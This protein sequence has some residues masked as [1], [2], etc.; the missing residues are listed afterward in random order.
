MQVSREQFSTS[1][2]TRLDQFVS[3]VPLCDFPSTCITIHEWNGW[4]CEKCILLR[5]SARLSVLMLFS[6]QSDNQSKFQ[7]Y[8]DD[9]QAMS[10]VWCQFW[11]IL[12]RWPLARVQVSRGWKCGI[13][14][15]WVLQVLELG[16]SSLLTPWMFNLVSV[17]LL[18]LMFECYA[19]S[20]VFWQFSA[21]DGKPMR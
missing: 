10:Y 16:L 3:L 13:F 21:N 18:K 9:V 11:S 1:D 5:F 12:S 8:P 6:H 20:S 2:L 14:K 7:V 19:V 4:F 15:N 17:C